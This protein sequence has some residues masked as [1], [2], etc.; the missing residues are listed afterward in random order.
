MNA[1]ACGTVE[2][3][4]EPAERQE[5]GIERR[6]AVLAQRGVEGF[7]GD[8]F[9]RE[10]RHAALGAGRHR[11]G[12]GGMARLIVD[13][14]FERGASASVC[15]GVRSSRKSFSAT[16]RPLAGSCARNT[17]PRLPAPT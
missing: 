10:V 13:E 1:L 9:L 8:I 5:R 11:R 3:L 14:G 17:G 16:N 12:N 15:S 2:P 6:R 4:G 7:P